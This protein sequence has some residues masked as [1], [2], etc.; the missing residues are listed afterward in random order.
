[1][2]SKVHRIYDQLS[3]SIYI[4][5]PSRPRQAISNRY[6]RYYMYSVP[7]YPLQKSLQREITRN[8]RNWQNKFINRDCGCGNYCF[9]EFKKYPNA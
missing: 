6:C 5:M 9:E 7:E 4:N 2:A 8:M 3:I 1:M